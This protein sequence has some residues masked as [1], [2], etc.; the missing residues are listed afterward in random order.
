MSWQTEKYG[1]PQ[2]SRTYSGGLWAWR[3]THDSKRSGREV[4]KEGRVVFGLL[5][6]LRSNF[7]ALS[8]MFDWDSLAWVENY[9]MVDP[10]SCYTC[11][12]ELE[13][14]SSIFLAT[15]EIMM[16]NI[17]NFPLGAP[18]F[19]A[20]FFLPVSFFPWLLESIPQ[21]QNLRVIWSTGCLWG[22]LLLISM[23][24]RLQE[25]GMKKPLLSGWLSFLFS[26]SCRSGWI[27]E[28]WRL[29]KSWYPGCALRTDLGG[30][31]G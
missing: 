28:F 1:G 5:A 8:E 20:N 26:F 15:P 24:L 11:R 21:P 31:S 14:Q 2:D 22:L 3:L 17:W 10:Q 12:S 27:P 25:T 4:D 7:C 30:L 18:P 6:L 16:R 13:L 9:A 23:T 19:N 29:Q